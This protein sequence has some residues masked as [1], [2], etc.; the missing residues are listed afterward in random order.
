MVLVS[1]VR[2]AAERDSRST[3]G[4]GSRREMC[5]MASSTPKA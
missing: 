3:R 1:M 2:P 5:R 4:S